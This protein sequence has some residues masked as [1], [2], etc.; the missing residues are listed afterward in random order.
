[1]PEKFVD[2]VEAS[3]DGLRPL[4]LFQVLWLN[5]MNAFFQ[6]PDLP[7]EK[8]AKLDLFLLKESPTLVITDIR[9]SRKADIDSD[10]CLITAIAKI[11]T[12][13]KKNP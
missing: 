11:K 10:Y 4:S 6:K 13:Y 9:A 3:E 1:M 8:G 12:A 7:G 5:V 2:Q